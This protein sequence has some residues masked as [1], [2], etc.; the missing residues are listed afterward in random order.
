METLKDKDSK[1]LEQSRFIDLLKIKMESDG[2]DYKEKMGFED[3]SSI[4][5]ENMTTHLTS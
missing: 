1:S 3:E 2:L 4:I 5:E